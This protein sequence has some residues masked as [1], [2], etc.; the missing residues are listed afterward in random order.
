M[1]GA[2]IVTIMGY[3][4]GV[5]GAAIIFSLNIK[6]LLSPNKSLFDKLSS[7]PPLKD[8]VWLFVGLVLLTA[9]LLLLGFF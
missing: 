6:L 5:L 7:M 4:F 8:I 2:V 3:I 1:V 9:G